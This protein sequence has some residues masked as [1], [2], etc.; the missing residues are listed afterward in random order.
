MSNELQRQYDL[1][2]SYFKTT[3]EPFDEINWTGKDLFLVY[4]DNIIE[5]YSYIELKELIEYL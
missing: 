5:K 3:T 2:Y 1:I 4:D